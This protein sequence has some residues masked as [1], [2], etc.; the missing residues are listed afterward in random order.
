M[1]QSGAN[2]SSGTPSAGAAAP[3]ISQYCWERARTIW[4]PASEVNMATDF[5]R[6]TPS[7][8]RILVLSA[9]LGAGAFAGRG[10]ESDL[11]GEQCLVG[12]ARQRRFGAAH[13]TQ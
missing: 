3:D 5:F 9:R 13:V 11:T 10:E 2:L 8:A 4:A 12:L 6:R 7:S 1:I